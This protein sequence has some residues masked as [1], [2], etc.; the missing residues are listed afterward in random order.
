MT[1]RR[2]LLALLGTLST[3]SIAGCN[4]PKDNDTTPSDKTQ[5]TGTSTT[6]NPDDYNVEIT[7]TEPSYTLLDAAWTK[8]DITIDTETQI[9]LIVANTGENPG[10]IN[11]AATA[12]SYDGY[13]FG[14]RLK[15]PG[16][17]LQ[18]DSG[19]VK[20]VTTDPF[21]PRY[22]TNHSVS[23]L[24]GGKPDEFPTL[25]TADDANISLP[26][27]PITVPNGDSY[28]GWYGVDNN[29][30]P[31]FSIDTVTILDS[32]LA[33]QRV[34]TPTTVTPLRTIPKYSTDTAYVFVNLHYSTP[35]TGDSHIDPKYLSFA[36]ESSLDIPETFTE[37]HHPQ[38][39]KPLHDEVLVNGTEG[40]GTLVFEVPKAKL[41]DAAFT[42]TRTPKKSSSPDVIWDV[43][44]TTQFAEF[45]LI[46]MTVPQTRLETDGSQDF[47]FTIK[48]TSNIEGVFHGG[49]QWTAPEYDDWFWLDV[50][51]LM[52]AKIDPGAE[53]TIAVSA[54]WE[55]NSDE[56]FDS[57]PVVSG[58]VTCRVVPFGTEFT[59]PGSE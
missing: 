16:G 46:D 39:N 38:P 57:Y 2:E 51:D 45:E 19:E 6:K 11:L 59:L 1:N 55:I 52:T 44:E 54:Y 17:T 47:E 48:N 35:E 29:H 30:G 41:D 36:E 18:F 8:N 58:D 13:E 33:G 49:L 15:I 32:I 56:G 40:K 53:E 9:E 28:M 43:N 3:T 31:T 25:Q 21:T 10:E 12:Q 26:V 7:T 5:T 14:T 4:I 50:T 22:A 20:R 37:I 27:D 34:P 42:V 24:V 23:L